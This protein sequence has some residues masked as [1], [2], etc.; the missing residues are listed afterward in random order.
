MRRSSVRVVL[1]VAC[2]L[3]FASAVAAQNA[4][5]TR[6]VNLRA[7]HSSSTAI[8]E[9]LEPSDELWVTSATPTA[10][11]FPAHSLAGNSGWVWAVNIRLTGPVTGDIKTTT[12]PPEEYRGCSLE[13][14]ASSASFRAANVKKNRITAPTPA[15]IDGQVTL[16]A[17]LQTG[18]DEQRW[19]D[20]RGASIVAWVYDVKPGGAETVNCGESEQQYKDSHIEVVAS[21]STTGK[22]RRVIVEVTP[23]WREFLH[24]QGEDWTSSTLATR[25]EHHWVRFTGW[26]FWDFPHKDEARNTNPG[27]A[28]VWRAT[29]WEIHPVTSIT[30]CPNNSPQGCE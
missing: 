22:T 8:R 21:A 28:N 1:L 3:R 24:D 18:N 20:T 19:S 29:A 9:H 25:L 5:V 14:A 26:L 16:A 6:N 27:G 4:V 15:D 13:G 23:R 11:Y 10:G 7:G 30:L 12:G 2:L 17:M